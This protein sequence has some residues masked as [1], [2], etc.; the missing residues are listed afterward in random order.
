LNPIELEQFEKIKHDA[1][2]IQFGQLDSHKDD[3]EAIAMLNRDRENIII[4]GSRDNTVK[5]WI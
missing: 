4:T 5:L 2:G 3:I 1:R